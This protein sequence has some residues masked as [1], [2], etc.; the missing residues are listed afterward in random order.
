MKI[1]QKISQTTVALK[2]CMSR[3]PATVF[4][5]LACYVVASVSVVFEFD[6][7]IFAYL[8]TSLA[9]GTALS[10]LAY[11]SFESVNLK[12]TKQMM[13]Y[14][15]CGTIIAEL[16]LLYLFYVID[17]EIYSCSLAGAGLACTVLVLY[18][19]TSK[20]KVLTGG[21]H[22]LKSAAFAS[23]VGA[24]IF[25]GGALCVGAFIM[26]IY[27]FNDSY[28]L[29]ILMFFLSL[30]IGILIFLSSL[31]LPNEQPE[32]PKKIYKSVLVYAELTIYFVLTAVLYLYLIKMVFMPKLPSG[33]VNPYVTAA[34]IAYLFNL[35]AVGCFKEESKLV[36]FFIKYGGILMLPLIIMQSYAIGVRLYYHGL[37]TLRMISVCSIIIT[38]VFAL[39][40]VI[41]KIGI[42]KPLLF[43]AV[44]V[45]AVTV[46]PF[47][48]INVPV[49]QQSYT[50][51]TL[52][53]E[54]GMITEDGSIIQN[55]ELDNETKSK[56]ASSHKYVRRNAVKPPDF[57]EGKQWKDTF[58]LF[59]FDEYSIRNNESYSVEKYFWFYSNIYGMGAIDI[60]E[61]S[62]IAFIDAYIGEGVYFSVGEGGK[63]FF[64]GGMLADIVEKYG[65]NESKHTEELPTE[66]IILDESTDMLIERIEFLYNRE[67]GEMKDV[68]IKAIVLF[69]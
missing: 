29:F 10:L 55:P 13:K 26:L 19:L 44:L 1:F 58:E 34:S 53:A 60:L 43:S 39:G 27:D 59:G 45:L 18:Y 54:N 50:L 37:T 66:F 40:T 20:G 12:N 5:V 32:T 46:T 57:L 42:G 21:A 8:C 9:V 38:F 22:L 14:V 36:R 41:K 52:L 56:I 63:T 2:N 17:I 6:N 23:L 61:Y 64:I 25:L 4:S 48:I 28:K 49:W 62:D 68:Y 51:E 30:T 15:F 7:E 3:F 65:M 31:H 16:I 33:G 11:I 47:N 35:F 67:T 69:K 24:V